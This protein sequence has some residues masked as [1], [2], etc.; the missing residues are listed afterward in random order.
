M[1]HKSYLLQWSLGKLQQFSNVNHPCPY[2]GTVYTKINSI[3]DRELQF[4]PLVPS[5]RYRIDVNVTNENR[6]IPLFI[7]QVFFSVSDHRIELV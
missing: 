7:G 2:N 4:E 5:G 1:K 6:K 3:S